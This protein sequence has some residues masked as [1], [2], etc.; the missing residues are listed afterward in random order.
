MCPIFSR[1]WRDGIA[2]LQLGNSAPGS[3]SVA[4]EMTSLI[5]LAIVNT[6]P[7]LGENYMLF[8]INKFPPALLLAF[9]SER[10]K[11]LMWPVRTISL[12]WYV[13]MASRWV[14]A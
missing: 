14:A 9:V 8:D 3:A 6:A 11:A 4:D 13:M 1:A 12:A 7:L 5:I 10:Y 2:S